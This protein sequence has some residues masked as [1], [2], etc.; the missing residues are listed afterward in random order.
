MKKKIKLQVTIKFKGLIFE[1][2]YFIE[3]G[4]NLLNMLPSGCDILNITYFDSL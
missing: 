3:E 4:F 1:R 2:D